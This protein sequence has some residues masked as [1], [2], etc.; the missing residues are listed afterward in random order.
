MTPPESKGPKPKKSRRDAPAPALV[1]LTVNPDTIPID[2]VGT[3]EVSF[4]AGLDGPAPPGG[5]QVEIAFSDSPAAVFLCQVAEGQ[6]TGSQ[7][8]RRG[9]PVGENQVQARL[10]EVTKTAVLNVVP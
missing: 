7:T 1:S 8:I 4:E 10:G 6:T 2:Q 3:T 5:V 9:S